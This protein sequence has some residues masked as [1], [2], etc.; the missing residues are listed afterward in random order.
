MRINPSFKNI[1]A[2]TASL[3]VVRRLVPTYDFMQKNAFE[4]LKTGKGDCRTVAQIYAALLGLREDTVFVR[5]ITKP[6][7][8]SAKTSAAYVH[9]LALEKSSGLVV[10]STGAPLEKP[11][12]HI[13]AVPA[14]KFDYGWSNEGEKR[15]KPEKAIKAL[16][17]ICS[18]SDRETR[19]WGR[20][21]LELTVEDPE[22]R[23]SGGNIEELREDALSRLR[24]MV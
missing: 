20:Y 3:D 5:H 23:L 8:P 21:Q 12:A 24:T 7:Q 2:S 17:N 10:H 4:A 11:G 14:S 9:Y 16:G 19:R 18:G 1:L 22:E 6:A 15:A 13:K